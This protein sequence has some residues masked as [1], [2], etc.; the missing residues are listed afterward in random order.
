MSPDDI[1]VQ[2]VPIKNEIAM[3]FLRYQTDQ[4]VDFINHLF[5]LFWAT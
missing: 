3:R 4:R 5:K 1:T 2:S